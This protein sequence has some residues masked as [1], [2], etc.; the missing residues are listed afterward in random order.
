MATIDDMRSKISRRFIYAKKDA[1]GM[2]G[3]NKSYFR[4]ARGARILLYHGLCNADPTRFNG[5]FLTRKTFE[6]HLEFYKEH[7]NV[8]TL[9]QF[10]NQQFNNDKFNVCLTFDDGFANNLKYALP[11][12]EKYQM[13][14]TFFITAIRDA[15]YEILWSDFLAIVT[16]YGPAR[17]LYEDKEYRKIK[18][19]RKYA[20]VA[21][22]ITLADRLK[23]LGFESK[24]QMMAT[25]QELFPNN[26][27]EED[28][29]KQLTPG[30]IRQLAASPLV[31]I[32]SHSYYHNRM[33]KL[34]IGD[35]SNELKKSKQFLESVTGY[36]IS[37]FA[38]PYGNYSRQ[39]VEEARRIGHTQLLAMDLLYEED[40]LDA[41]MRERLTMNPYISVNNQMYA[42]VTGHY[43]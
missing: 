5:I 31:T 1:L 7:F 24:K 26:P 36:E 9:D 13:P 17:L 37:S 2:L 16:H 38:F 28:Y 22:G 6:A 41:A 4:N 27:A 25:L 35:A 18:K 3:L 29:W 30:E 19:L 23:G 40:K 33:D 21:T 15:G 12:L 20:E 43:E 42:T 8:V 39:L 10:Y 11:L 34:P 14:A 32:G